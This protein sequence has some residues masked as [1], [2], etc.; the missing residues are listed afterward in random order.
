MQGL[1]TRILAHLLRHQRKAARH[2]LKRLESASDPEALHDFRVALR[3]LRSLLRSY[4]EYKDH[5]PRRCRKRLRR[6][7]RETGQARDREVQLAW[8]QQS[9]REAELGCLGKDLRRMLAKTAADEKARIRHRLPK[10]WQK[11]SPCLERL[12]RWLESEEG[13]PAF[14]AVH[15]GHLHDALSEL[16]RALAEIKPGVPDDLIHQARIA[17]K[18]LRYLVLPLRGELPEADRVES[19]LASLQELMGEFNDARVWLQDLPEL[20]QEPLRKLLAE[21]AVRICGELQHSSGHLLDEDYLAPLAALFRLLCSRRQKAL[22]AI[23][24]W[25][26]S[27]EPAVLGN[28]VEEL[29]LQLEPSMARAQ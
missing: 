28:R 20:L 26:N 8:L 13:A 14:G 29:I 4:S 9:E 11:L 16:N 12:E 24:A 5:L 15:A 25:L 10:A 2:V 18:R 21:P 22:E 19:E 7:A 17:G 23:H 27:G 6:L 1:F 3:R